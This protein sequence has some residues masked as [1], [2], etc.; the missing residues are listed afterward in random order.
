MRVVSGRPFSL[1]A[2]ILSE[3]EV[4]RAPYVPGFGINYGRRLAG[5]WLGW[6]S[7][8]YSIRGRSA[9]RQHGEIAK[10]SDGPAVRDHVLGEHKIAM[11]SGI[12]ICRKDIV[13]ARTVRDAEKAEPGTVRRTLDQA[14][15]AGKEP[16]K[17]RFR[18]A[19][20]A[21]V[22]LELRRWRS[23]RSAPPSD[24]ASPGLLSG[25]KRGAFEKCLF[26]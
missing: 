22:S 14:I 2:L 20:A 24:A 9:V 18:R 5:C 7:R 26:R 16:S 19:I 12:R 17:A 15:A 21:T 1:K 8:S 6:G 4:I 13:E 11:T 3:L 10:R 25:H 23:F